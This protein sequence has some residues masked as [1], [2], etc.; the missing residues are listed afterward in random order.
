MTGFRI[1]RCAHLQRE[2]GVSGG[3]DE[4]R[5]S[6]LDW[7]L[8]IVE[9]QRG[10][11]SVTRATAMA[12]KKKKGEGGRRRGGNTSRQVWS[13][14][15]DPL[16]SSFSYFPCCLYFFLF[17][18]PGA[19]N[20]RMIEGTSQWGEN[21]GMFNLFLPKEYRESEWSQSDRTCSRSLRWSCTSSKL[22]TSFSCHRRSSLSTD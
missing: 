1:K 22:L 13:G 15:E 6:H 18:R 10:L 17:S 5:G 7:R 2:G 3:A 12:K 16:L 8:E 9:G 4:I 21:N 19:S 14:C 11:W 20:Q